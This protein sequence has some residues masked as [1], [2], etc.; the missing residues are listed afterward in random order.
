MQQ[1]ILVSNERCFLG[2]TV[3]REEPDISVNSEA[4]FDLLYTRAHYMR[5]IS[6]KRGSTLNTP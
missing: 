5:I 4:H 3:V 2:H 6:P 1:Y